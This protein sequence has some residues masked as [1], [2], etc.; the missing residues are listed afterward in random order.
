MCRQE[1]PSQVESFATEVKCESGFSGL[2]I[3]FQYR[4]LSSWDATR[5]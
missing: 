2:W 1:M 3:A 4:Q 5:P